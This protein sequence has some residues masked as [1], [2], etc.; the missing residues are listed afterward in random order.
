MNKLN[1]K[2]DFDFSRKLL[3]RT[4]VATV[5]GFSFCSNSHKGKVQVRFTFCKKIETL[6]KSNFFLII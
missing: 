2:N 1:A 6:E 3:Y 4:K 5:P